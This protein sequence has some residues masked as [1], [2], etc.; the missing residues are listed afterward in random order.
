MGDMKLI[1]TLDFAT[2]GVKN[3][4]VGFWPRVGAIQVAE[5]VTGLF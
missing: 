2:C 5:M 4:T 3:L 1:R